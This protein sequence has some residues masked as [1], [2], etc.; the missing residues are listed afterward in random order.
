M[1]THSRF[2][3]HVHLHASNTLENNQFFFSTKAL[4]GFMYIHFNPRVLEWIIM[5]LSLIPPNPLQHMWIEM[6]TC[7]S[8]QALTI[9]P[10]F[11]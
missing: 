11:K 3:T 8:K 1:N 9:P 4:F 5:E 2:A 6:D 7:A 10:K